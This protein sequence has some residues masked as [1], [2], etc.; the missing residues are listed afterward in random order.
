MIVLRGNVKECKSLEFKKAIENNKLGIRES[1]LCVYNVDTREFKFN[2][3]INFNVILVYM[4][5]VSECSIVT[6]NGV[7]DLVEKGL[8]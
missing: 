3:E 4:E 6:E 5:R 1:S 2:G 7:V 8:I